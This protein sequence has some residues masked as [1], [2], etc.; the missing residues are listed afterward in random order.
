MPYKEKRRRKFEKITYFDQNRI[1]QG[2]M[3]RVISA[4]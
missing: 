4:D 1:A 2:T 3:F